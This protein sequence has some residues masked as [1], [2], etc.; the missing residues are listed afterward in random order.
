MLAREYGDYAGH[1]NHRVSV[2]AYAAQHPGVEG[3]QAMRSVALHLTRLCL[4]VER[5]LRPQAGRELA[6][7]LL[8]EPGDVAWLAPPGDRGVVT[9]GD[10]AAAHGRDAHVASVDAWGRAVWGAWAEHHDTV[11][12]WADAALGSA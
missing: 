11:R 9:V 1:A 5:G 4:V 3:P 12:R 2:D 10:V 8:P 7:M 6:S